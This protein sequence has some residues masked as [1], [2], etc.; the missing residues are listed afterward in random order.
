MA[1]RLVQSQMIRAQ[2]AETMLALRCELSVLRRTHAEAMA[3]VASTT[4]EEVSSKP[5]SIQLSSVGQ[6]DHVCSVRSS[7]DDDPDESHMDGSVT[8]SLETPPKQ[9]EVSVDFLNPV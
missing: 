6:T 4:S 8:D 3:T 1:D 2:E 7:E 5:Q 9:S